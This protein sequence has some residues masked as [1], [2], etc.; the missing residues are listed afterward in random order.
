MEG[1]R[2][3]NHELPASDDIEDDS[4][5]ELSLGLS[6][7]GS[8]NKEKCGEALKMDL[9]AEPGAGDGKAKN[10]R[11]SSLHGALKRF[12][13]G[14]LED[15]D[16]SARVLDGYSP[17]HSS[18]SDSAGNTPKDQDTSVCSLVASGIARHSSV[19][20]LK[21]F[22][23]AFGQGFQLKPSPLELLVASDGKGSSP[24]IKDLQIPANLS[25]SSS[26]GQL[27]QQGSH[28]I[29]ALKGGS[30][31]SPGMAITG[32]STS[33]VIPHA[34]D[35]LPSSLGHKLHSIHST[36]DVSQDV[37][38]PD[39]EKFDLH[40]NAVLHHEMWEQQRKFQ[41]ARKKR[42][43]LI[44]EQ[45]HQKK[46]K[47]D[48]DRTA[49]THGFRRP[50]S[51]TWARGLEAPITHSLEAERPFGGSQDAGEDGEQ[52]LEI[53]GTLH[54]ETDGTTKE[55][56]QEEGTDTPTDSKDSDISQLQ[57]WNEQEMGRLSHV[58]VG[59]A[60]L[61]KVQSD[62]CKQKLVEI[63]AMTDHATNLEAAVAFGENSQENTLRNFP[64]L[65]GQHPASEALY[66]SCQLSGSPTRKESGRS[67]CQNSSTGSQSCEKKEEHNCGR[68]SAGDGE[69]SSAPRTCAGSDSGLGPASG[70][71]I[72]PVAV[73]SGALPYPLPSFSV[74]PMPY[75]VPIANAQGMPFPVG[76]SFPYLMQL[77]PPGVDNQESNVA[78]PLN[79][80]S[81]H[82]PPGQGYLP[83][84]IPSL[85]T[86]TS[87]IPI[88][89]PPPA[90]TLCTP[91]SGVVPNGSA[92]GIAEDDAKRLQG[93]KTAETTTGWNLAT[94]NDK[95]VQGSHSLQTTAS[96][97]LIRDPTVAFTQLRQAA[98]GQVLSYLPVPAAT[99]LGPFSTLPDLGDAPA[100]KEQGGSGVFPGFAASM[101]AAQGY[102]ATRLASN[103]PDDVWG[104]EHATRQGARG[105]DAG[106]RNVNISS[107]EDFGQGLG[108]PFQKGST[109]NL[110]L[111]DNL[112]PEL[113]NLR[114]GIATDLKFGGTGSSPDLPWVSTTGLGPNG[115]TICGVLY[116]Q[117]RNQLKIVCACHGRHMSPGEFVQHAGGDVLNPEN[118]VV[119]SPPHTRQPASA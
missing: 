91:P 49:I 2:D 104:Q 99:Q 71:F 22:D 112:S 20:N 24:S 115:K 59:N 25:A 16:E 47:K 55:T 80:N 96:L 19:P 51:N 86:T 98:D 56:D 69:V 67:S 93:T 92:S 79:G 81:F 62:V 9:I 119:N 29:D 46:S 37:R 83:Y 77:V 103:N 45:K 31:A 23:P 113:L 88:L 78:R 7:G 17:D 66:H 44:E 54:R 32:A 48:E 116:R 33:S 38:Q 57:R 87:W 73:T 4:G 114:P 28:L 65:L 58:P 12:L 82:L 90:P 63:L 18:W 36:T 34:V 61:D 42:K 74:V 60:D 118:T 72:A 52:F 10:A 70:S 95:F 94:S 68:S 89:R 30:T 102:G 107:L 13:Q 117:C 106:T 108:G 26:W 85:E 105:N 97:N 6:C 64:K 35:V 40:R 75:T 84:Q 100:L 111:A 1:S 43:H 41:E 8:R 50:G 5:L 14:R 3:R 109:E 39:A 101:Q 53:K 76:F 110:A 27:Q 15:Q 11:L 21:T